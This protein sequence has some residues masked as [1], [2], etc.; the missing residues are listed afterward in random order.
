MQTESTSQQRTQTEAQTLFLKQ[1]FHLSSTYLRL[2]AGLDLSSTST[3]F[4]NLHLS[5][6]ITS[7][8]CWWLPSLIISARPLCVYVCM[9][10]W[11]GERMTLQRQK[12]QLNAAL[13]NWVWYTKIIGFSQSSVILFMQNVLSFLLLLLSL[14]INESLLHLGMEVPLSFLH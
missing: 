3:S 12:N 1:V 5:L 14:F 11:W 4:M 6:N 13:P 7:R 10:T 2:S 9:Y 8:S